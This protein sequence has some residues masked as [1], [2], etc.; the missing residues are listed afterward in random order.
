LDII[1][2]MCI[3][4]IRKDFIK[5]CLDTLYKYTPPNFRVIIVDQS[6]GGIELPDEYRSKVHL[7]VYAYRPL[8]FAK[9]MNTAIR[10]ADT[11]YITVLNDDVRFINLRWWDGI[12]E[13]FKVADNIVAVNPSSVKEA[14][15]GY[16]WPSDK[17]VE[18]LPYKEEYTDAD[19]DFLLK[20]DFSTVAN[21]PDTFPRHKEGVTDAIATW[22]TV[23]KREA[24]LPTEDEKGIRQA[25]IGLYDERLYPAGFEDYDMDGRA[26]SG[27]WRG[28]KLRMVGASKSYVYHHWSQSKDYLGTLPQT[29]KSR[30]W[31]HEHLLWPR[32]WNEGH[33]FDP[34]G[35]Y[36]NDKGEIVELKR[37]PEVAV[38]E[39]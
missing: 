37:V 1:N 17:Y 8:G 6:V 4:C 9:A 19:Y 25:K 31:N 7:Y 20:G 27:A 10:L 16:G 11:P 38:V 35:H 24:L 18:L 21:L 30:Y 13:T 22:C 5:D 14:G 2:T 12:M 26:Y 3:T 39:L 36:T 15:W 33:K 32:E 29:D 28:E 23:F 34:W